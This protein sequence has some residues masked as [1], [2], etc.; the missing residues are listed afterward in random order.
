MY[1]ECVCMYVCAHMHAC[2]FMCIYVHISRT[3]NDTD[4]LLKQNYFKNIYK[5]QP[6]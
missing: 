5:I 2:T 6:L 4:S 1:V 3:N